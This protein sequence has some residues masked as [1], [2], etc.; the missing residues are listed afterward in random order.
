MFFSTTLFGSYELDIFVKIFLAVVAGAVIGLE[1]EKHGRPAGL[2]THLLVSAG[3]CLM[4][5]VSEAFFLKYGDLPGTG[6][7][8]IDPGR[9]AAQ[10]IT[11]IGFLG[12]GVIIKEGFVVR[13]LTTAACLWMVAG[14]GMAFGMGLISGGIIGTLV[15]LF[16]LIALKKLEPIIKKDRY[17]HIYVTAKAEPDIYPQLEDIFADNG[18]RLSNIEADWNLHDGRV[19]YRLVLTQ[20][21]V[22]IGREISRLISQI[23]G[24]QKISYK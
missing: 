6:V 18:L 13:G 5:I 2:R 12:A 23:E 19:S 4:M 9:A 11:G 7:V 3:S 15:A 1:R 24:V 8:R 20:H 10:I 14:I 21:K 22:R 16:S 17:L